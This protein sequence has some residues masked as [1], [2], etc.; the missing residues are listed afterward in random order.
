MPPATT[1]RIYTCALKP[2]VADDTFFTRDSG[3]LCRSFQKIGVVSK[4]IMPRRDEGQKDPSDDVVRATLE[5]LHTPDW[6]R[7]LNIDAVAIVTWGHAEDTPVVRAAKES[8]IKVVLVTDD[9]EGAKVRFLNLIKMTW[10]RFY[11]LP[12]GRRLIEVVAKTPLLYPWLLWRKHGR[13]PQYRYAD[14]IT[15][16]TSRIASNVQQGLQ[17]QSKEKPGFLLGYPSSTDA[18]QLFTD[19]DPTKPPSV[20]AVARWDAIKHKRPHFLMDV[21]RT[22]LG[23]DPNITIHIYGV[24]LP[25][26]HQIH[27]GLPEAQKIRFFLHGFCDNKEILARMRE[28]EIAFCPSAGECGPVPMAEA[29]CQGCS[30][31]GGGNVAEWAAKTHYGTPVPLDTPTAFADAVIGELQKWQ[32]GTYNRRD[33][34]LFWREHYSAT[35]FAEK[36]REFVE[37]GANAVS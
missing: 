30:I 2:F 11:H 29:L 8:G 18:N 28:S 31:V 3:L 32:R 37:S 21:C 14:M 35:R 36:I 15:C 27:D 1:L 24:T 34:A 6:W 16:W 22:L 33:T 12:T 17:C 20:I 5:E 23:N 7:A 4:V 10:R 25:F 13:Y 26:M 19:K 9:G